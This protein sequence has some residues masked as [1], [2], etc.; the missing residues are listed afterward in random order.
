[1]SSCRAQHI[2]FV[3]DRRSAKAMQLGVTWYDG[4]LA[5]KTLCAALE[6]LGL[7]SEDYDMVNAYRDSGSL[8]KAALQRVKHAQ[9]CGWLIIGMGKRAQKALTAFGIPHRPMMHPAARGRI[10]CRE[11]Y[12]AHVA[13]VLQGREGH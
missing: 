7:S 10:R 11:V 8:D 3:G 4:R 5:A 13:D 6:L 2:I 1:M 12:Q 9:A